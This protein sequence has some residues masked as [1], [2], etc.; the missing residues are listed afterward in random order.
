MPA[1][2]DQGGWFGYSAKYYTSGRTELVPTVLEVFANHN[3]IINVA[4]K[5]PEL[6]IAVLKVIRECN[7][8]TPGRYRQRFDGHLLG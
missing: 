8:N 4:L 2:W 6:F 3:K 1:W 5:D 7:R